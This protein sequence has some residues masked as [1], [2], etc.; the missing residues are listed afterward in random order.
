M[1][2][3]RFLHREMVIQSALGHVGCGGYL[4]HG[5]RFVTVGFK[6]RGGGAGKVLQG[7]QAFAVSTVWVLG[8]AHANDKYGRH[9]I[10]SIV[11]HSFA[12]GGLFS[13]RYCWRT[14][15]GSRSQ[16]RKMRRSRFRVR[17]FGI[18]EQ[19]NSERT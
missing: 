18:G 17:N 16:P 13:K 9:L 15:A 3:H 7:P 19:R 2:Q 14:S 1:R 8:Y 12:S 10:L 11:H 5:D 6:Q 4:L